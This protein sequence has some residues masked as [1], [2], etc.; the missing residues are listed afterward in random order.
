M[1]AVWGCVVYGCGVGLWCVAYAVW[2]GGNQAMLGG[3][4]VCGVV[5]CRAVVCWGVLC[6]CTAAHCVFCLNFLVTPPPPKKMP[7][8]RRTR[9]PSIMEPNRYACP[10]MGFAF[11]V[12]FFYSANFWRG[13]MEFCVLISTPRHMLDAAL[14]D[15]QIRR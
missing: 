2:G 11:V 10:P 8:P 12:H 15:I 7:P 14:V 1:G 13:A 9:G 6:G 5:V 3:H 4:L